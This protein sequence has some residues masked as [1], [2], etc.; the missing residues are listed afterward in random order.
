MAQNN[1]GN[2]LLRLGERQGSKARFE[3][4]VAAFREALK[5]RTRERTPLEWAAAQNN[6]GDACANLAGEESH[7]GWLEQAAEAFREAA[8]EL[9]RERA[10]SF[11]RRRR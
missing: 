2:A 8:K 1:L 11:G 10:P 4:A 5:E 9:T 7:I 6:L 3:E